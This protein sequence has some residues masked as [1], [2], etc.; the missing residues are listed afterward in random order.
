MKKLFGTDGIRGKANREPMTAMMALKLGLSVAKMFK[1]NS[2]HP[3]ILIGKDT[4]VSCYMLEAAIVSGTTA[5]GCDALLVGPLPTPGVA[6]LITT[7]R[8]DAGIMISASH[9]PYEDNGIKVFGGDGFKLDD[10]LELEI[11]RL[12]ETIGDDDQI[13]PVGRDLGHAVRVDDAVGRYAS[14]LKLWFPREYS[15]EGMKIVCDAANGAAY[16]TAPIVFEELGAR[17]FVYGDMPNGTNINDRCGSMHPSLLQEKVLEHGA[18][19]GIALDGDADRVILVDEKGNLVDGN[20]ILYIAAKHF[21]STDKL[22]CDAIVTTTM[23]NMGLEVTLQNSGIHMHRT[24][25]GD[26]YVVEHMRNHGVNLGGE[27]SGHVIFLDTNTTAD[28]ILTALQMIAVMKREKKPLSELSSDLTLYPQVMI[29]I[30]VREKRPFEDI[31][32]FV[33]LK[34]KMEDRLSGKGR[35]DVRYSGTQKVARVMCEGED[36][37]VVEETARELA[38]YLQKSVGQG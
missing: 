12:M 2:R 11:E 9:N 18:D 4:R 27:P 13:L 15:L 22:T 10:R 26:R 17:C 30:D 29:N 21:K 1:R 20:A 38:D 8:A 24:Q 31:R 32:G 37:T 28:G 33:E 36:Q 35:V 16:K 3:K 14:Y 7:M 19:I 23:A 6:H 5:M 25:V 34:K